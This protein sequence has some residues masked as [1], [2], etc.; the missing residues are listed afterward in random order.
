MMLAQLAA[1]KKFI[2]LKSNL[3]SPVFF[4]IWGKIP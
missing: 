2:V 3:W 4:C 1:V